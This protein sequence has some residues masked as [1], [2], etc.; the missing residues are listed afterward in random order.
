[1]SKGYR[2]GSHS[3]TRL[4]AHIVWLTKYR[5]KVIKGDIQKGGRELKIQVC[6]AEDV[7]ILKE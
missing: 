5:Y 4:T 6:D 3:V 1:L 7:K 2:H